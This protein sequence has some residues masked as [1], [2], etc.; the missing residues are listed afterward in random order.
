MYG[1]ILCF[2]VFYAV[3]IPRFQRIKPTLSRLGSNKISMPNR[4]IET[5]LLVTATLFPMNTVLRA[6]KS[7][8]DLHESLSFLALIL[9]VALG[10]V[11][12]MTKL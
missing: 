4:L 9:G 11:A 1:F 8:W 5:W 10:M 6:R 12:D 7:D 3:L 2:V